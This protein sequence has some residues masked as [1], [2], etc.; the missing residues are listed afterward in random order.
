[1]EGLTTQVIALS[2][3]P[4]DL[5]QLLSSL[6][7][8]EVLLNNSRGHIPEALGLL[9]YSLH[10]LGVLFYL[11]ALSKGHTYTDAEDAVFVDSV[12]R[13]LQVAIA[14]QVR[15]AP[16]AFCGLCRRFKERVMGMGCSSRGVLPLLNA[17]RL[18]QPSTD[19]LTPV[20]SD[21]LQLCLLAKTYNAAASLLEED[22]FDVDP[23]QT[24][25]TPTDLFLYA[26]Y[27]G[28]LCL[29]RGQ[30]A[31]STDLFLHALT[32]PATTGNAIV[33]ACYKKYV[34]V[35]LLHLGHLPPLPKFTST[36]VKQVSEQDC[37]AYTELASS[38][39]SQNVTLVQRTA[40][41]HASTYQQD[42]N[43]GLLKQV[44]A[45]LPKRY[46]QRLT[47]TYVTLSLAD[48]AAKA[49]LST[50]AQAESLVLKMVEAGEIHATINQRDGMVRFLDDPE[51]FNNPA[52]VDR[53]N[54]QLRKCMG[55]AER[56]QKFNDM[57]SGSVYIVG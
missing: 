3:S 4:G 21:F 30:L 13:F 48:I 32:A 44:L 11:D 22:I 17:V 41:T 34:L 42:G 31:R 25:C 47:L 29:G 12:T 54:G 20:H 33:V 53:I 26:Y 38:Y 8:S 46:V 56:L 39:G 16:E 49:G 23:S 27:G 24:C 14:A 6:K 52:V 57:V 51:Q 15:L 1:M 43:L 50:A 55:L 19:F 18:L 36:K 45:G 9:D 7:G 2:Y 10:S 5:S 40:E 37:R 35:S 28:M